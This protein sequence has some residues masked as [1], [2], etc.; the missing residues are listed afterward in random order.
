[1]SSS[2]EGSSGINRHSIPAS[3]T[4]SVATMLCD[5]NKCTGDE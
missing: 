3:L 2:G 5:C 4:P 1:M